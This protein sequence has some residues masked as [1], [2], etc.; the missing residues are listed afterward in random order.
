MKTLYKLNY[1][2]Y[3]NFLLGHHIEN[4]EKEEI[5]EMGVNFNGLQ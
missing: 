5:K 4:I 2:T 3:C 1:I